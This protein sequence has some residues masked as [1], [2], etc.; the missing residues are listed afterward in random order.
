MRIQKQV[1]A[2]RRLRQRGSSMVE[3]ALT[4]SIFLMFMFG[5]VE[6][7]RAMFV[8]NQ[9]AFLAEEGARYASTRGLTVPSAQQASASNV[10]TI[11]KNMAVA[12]PTANMTVTTT[13]QG[14]QGT[15][16][17]WVKVQVSYPF[18]FIGPYMPYSNI[19]LSSTAQT[20]VLR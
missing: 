12:I 19:N 4:V 18:T 17:Q 14:T 9:L 7:G 1:S 11:V 10:S 13:W 6:F 16:G 2:A 15:V 3:T 20:T 8:H 5:T